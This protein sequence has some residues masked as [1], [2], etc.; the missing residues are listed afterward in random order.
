MGCFSM[1]LGD[2]LVDAGMSF[3]FGELSVF[4]GVA[5]LYYVGGGRSV[6]QLGEVLVGFHGGSEFCSVNFSI[7][8][9]V[10]LFKPLINHIMGFISVFLVTDMFINA[11]VSFLNS[12]A[13]GVVSVAS[14]DDLSGRWAIVASSVRS[15]LGSEFVD[16]D[17]SASVLVDTVE[18]IIDHFVQILS[19]FL[20]TDHFVNAGVS[21]LFSDTTG[22]VSVA[23]IHNLSRRW[24]ISA[25]T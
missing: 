1:L 17:L 10:C 3:L 15:H 4:R 6:H 22:I 20:I 21:F 12:K 18:G 9:R 11:S 19:L 2:V 7:S 25:I 8:V 23:G 14:L 24:A 16:V 13:T 5:S